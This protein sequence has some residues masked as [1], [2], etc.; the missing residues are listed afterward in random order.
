MKNSNISQAEQ[1]QQKA[2]HESTAEH[3]TGLL[4]EGHEAQ[5]IASALVFMAI[6]MSLQLSNQ[7]EAV[8]PILMASMLQAFHTNAQ[9]NAND[10]TVSLS[11]QTAI[12]S[13]QSIH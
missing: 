11:T 3:I 2:I 9:K 1:E 4:N 6:D 12:S 5:K 7:K 8:F 10:M 13:S